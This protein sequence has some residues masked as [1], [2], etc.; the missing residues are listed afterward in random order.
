VLAVQAALTWVPFA[1]F[2]SHWQQGIDGLLAGLVLLMVPGQVA[3]PLGGGTGGR[4]H[5]PARE[6]QTY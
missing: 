1:V 6:V 4:G 5:T 2:G 3:W